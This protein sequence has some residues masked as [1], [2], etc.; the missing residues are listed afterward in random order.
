MHFKER[1]LPSHAQPITSSD[2]KQG[3][4]YFA[5]NYLDEDMTVPVMESLV[6]IGRDLEP[7]DS[8]QVYFQNIESYQRGIKYGEVIE[9]EPAEFSA[10]SETEVNHIF[11]F[12][13]ALEEL[14]RCS[15]RRCEKGLDPPLIPR[16]ERN[17]PESQRLDYAPTLRFEDHELQA[18]FI[19][20]LREAGL[21]FEVRDDGAVISAA[22][23]WPA[24]NAVA[25][26]IRDSC[27]RWYFVW[28]KSSEM[29]SRF[30]EE[31]RAAGLPFQ[32]EHHEDRIV[33]LLPK[34]NEDLHRA[35][36]DRL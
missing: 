21:S 34:G 13:K 5:V 30:W 20:A 10:G 1:R 24:L 26:T 32:V 33:F 17:P 19:A 35:V 12:E 6:F 3:G 2:L 7:G 29:A 36:M 22:V 18:C 9:G 25:S 31:M 28:W 16:G 11:D 14:M 23:D 27:F 4:I 8:G 15:L